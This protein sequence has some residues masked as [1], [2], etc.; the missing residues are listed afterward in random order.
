[1]NES[2]VQLYDR[3]NMR[4]LLVEFPRQAEEA[5]RIGRA[6]KIPY[7]ASAIGEIVVT[8]LGGSAIGGDLLRSYLSE[9]LRIPFAVNRHYS[10]PAYV[11]KKSLVI[12]SS[13]SGGTEETIA[14]HLDARKR[15]AMVLCVTSGGETERLAKKFK[16]PVVK[17]PKGLPPR[18]ALAYSFFPS[19]IAL[20]KMKLIASRD[21]EIAETIALLAKK[22]KLYASLRGDNPALELARQLY[23]KLPIIYSAADRF[24][25]V[26]VRWRGQMA[27]NAKVLAFGHVIPEMNHNEIVGWKVLQRLMGDMTAVFLRDKDDHPRIQTRMHI[28]KGIVSEFAGKVIEVNS[29]GRSLLART[30]SLIYLGDWTS[31]Y[32]ALLNGIDPTPVRVIDYLK[33]E[34]GKK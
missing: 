7:R 14:A 3:G 5:V 24:D 19:L 16:Q 15:K 25:A 10:L 9:S 27:E 4:K 23:N 13:Y 33:W 30:F 26:N 31:Y 29:E 2:S 28:T 8:G 12:V 34:L 20:A 6:A 18:T 32:L 17:I 21:A 22:S 1:M 11:G